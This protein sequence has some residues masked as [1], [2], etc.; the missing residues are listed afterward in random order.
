MG[1]NPHR[2]NMWWLP[3]GVSV[4]AGHP[5]ATQLAKLAYAVGGCCGLEG[6]A[7]PR[8]RE[9]RDA[10]TAAALEVDLVVCSA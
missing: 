8:P 1:S 4:Q 5:A 6:F 7:D 2:P 9:G 10:P 3:L